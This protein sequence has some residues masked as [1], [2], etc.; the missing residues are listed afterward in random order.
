MRDGRVEGKVAFVTGAARGQGRS[1]AVRLAE[2]GADIIAV[3]I[4]E[5]I[6]STT[7]PL[8][9]P[10]D[11]DETAR[12]VEDHGR[13][14]VTFRADVRERAQLRSALESGVASL[15]RLDVV[16]AQAGI[17]PMSPR[18]GHRRGSM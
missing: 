9:R 3:D 2:E 4:C 1:H 12:L 18:W 13:R 6:A 17:M 16:V 8:A 14:I 15:G 5:D 7:Y 10:E 11:L